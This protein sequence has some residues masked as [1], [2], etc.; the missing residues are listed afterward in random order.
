MNL[1]IIGCGLVG[2]KRALAAR[3]HRILWV[4]DVDLERARSLASEVS[5][6]RVTADWR[7]V[8][9]EPDVQA[10]IVATPHNL[11]APITLQALQAGKHVLV[12]KPGARSTA[13][14]EPVRKLAHDSRLVVKVGFNHRFHPALA[15]AKRMIE[16]GVAG[17]LMFVRGLYGHGGRPGYEKEWRADPRLSGGGEAIDQGIHL[18]DLA[19]WMLGDFVQAV[20][21]A[22]TCFWPMSVEDNCFMLLRT[23]SG[24]C[25]FLHASWTEWKNMFCFEIYGRKA[26]LRIDGLGGS[27]GTERLTFYRML[28]QMGPP[29]IEVSEYPGPDVS[30]A[31]ELQNFVAAVEKGAPLCGDLDDARAALRIVENIRRHRDAIG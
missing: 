15:R 23:S 31:N 22:P 24:Q 1:A 20:G 3:N 7:Q 18:V 28:P 6:A 25:A 27:Y 2:R 14:L 13:E 16:E 10:V 17:P 29:E 21:Y 5:G 26:K 12:E 4:A 8:L 9:D 19:R 11:L 30:W